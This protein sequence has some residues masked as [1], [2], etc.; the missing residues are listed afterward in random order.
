MFVASRV[1]WAWRRSKTDPTDNALDVKKLDLAADRLAAAVQSQWEKEA[2][3]QGL[4]GADPIQI[5]WGTPSAPTLSG[6]A[7]GSRYRFT[8]F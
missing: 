2:G 5:T 4:T 7:A 8:R 3:E 1:G 6:R